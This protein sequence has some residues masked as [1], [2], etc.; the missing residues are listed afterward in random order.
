[1]E[2]FSKGSVSSQHCLMPNH[3]LFIIVIFSYLFVPS[4]PID[5]IL[6]VKKYGNKRE[7]DHSGYSLLPDG[8]AA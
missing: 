2:E 3:D 8:L 7:K 5:I 1:M 4:F 6:M